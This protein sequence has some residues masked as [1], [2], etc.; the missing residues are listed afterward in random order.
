M[1]KSR[2]E[3]REKYSSPRDNYRSVNQIEIDEVEKVLEES[4]NK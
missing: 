4:K 2:R 3:W 1:N